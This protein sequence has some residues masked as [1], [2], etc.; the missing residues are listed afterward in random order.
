MNNKE[1][2]LWL[3]NEVNEKNDKAWAV[4]Q[5]LKKSVSIFGFFFTVFTFLGLSI[6][7]IHVCQFFPFKMWSTQK[8]SLSYSKR[9]ASIKLLYGKSFLVNVSLSSFKK[10][11][12]HGTFVFRCLMATHEGTQYRC[13][14]S[15][16]V[17]NANLTIESVSASVPDP[18]LT[19]GIVS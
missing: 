19:I 12:K 13:I 3:H 8:W 14:R 15:M 17:P 16:M 4:L 7:F 10:I 5:Q 2:Y 1:Y 11:F 6:D 9:L 18:I